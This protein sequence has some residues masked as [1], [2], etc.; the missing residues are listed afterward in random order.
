MPWGLDNGTLDL[1]QPFEMTDEEWQAL[2]KQRAE[3]LGHPDGFPMW[4]VW[5]R[6]RPDIIK[7]HRMNMRH[8]GPH[9]IG[10]GSLPFLPADLHVYLLTQY[11]F[12]V[13]Y[14]LCA[15]QRLGW[16]R[17]DIMDVIAVAQLTSI[18]RGLNDSATPEVRRTL[19]NWDDPESPP[20]HFPAHWY[21]DPGALISGIT[22]T[23]PG[24]TD[25]EVE[26]LRA[27][28]L[29]VAGEVPSWFDFLAEYGRGLMKTQRLRW[30]R[31]LRV[32]PPAALPFYE[33]HFAV[34]AG[35][36][37]GIRENLLIGKGLGMT[38]KELA[39]TILHG[40]IVT[41]GRSALAIAERAVGDILL[42]R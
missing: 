4:Q 6:Y 15:A 9:I 31:A 41:G 1:D 18:S 17:A 21:I 7:S 42:S 29:R 28:Y 3:V 19:E 36:G 11:K 13:E 33:L 5:R 16:S 35:N 22:L 27:W 32:Q 30:E 10:E 25:E 37:P 8:A 24:M 39:D 12:G 2:I 26:L 40:S 14:E 20:Q 23:E 34:V 38:K